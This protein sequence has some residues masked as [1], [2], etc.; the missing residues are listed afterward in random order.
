MR[1]ASNRSNGMDL[2]G[3]GLS[4]LCIIHC[5]AM[6][7]ILIVSP[8]YHL[9]L[10]N[11]H[12]HQNLFVVL[13][14]IALWSLYRGFRSHQNQN[15]L[16][17]GAIGLFILLLVAMIPHS[18]NTYENVLISGFNSLGSVLLVVAHVLN[19]RSHKHC[20]HKLCHLVR[21]NDE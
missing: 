2:L 3:I 17:Y 5:F 16:I 11:L 15:V 7:V 21:D 19:L 13:L 6:P 8:F 12:F 20:Q 9:V 4:I 10:D 1:V 14:G 18:H